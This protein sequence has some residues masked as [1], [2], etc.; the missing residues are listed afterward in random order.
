MPVKTGS[1]K[2]RQGV[3]N[4]TI[5][6]GGGINS[7]APEAQVRPE[8][9][10]EGENFDLELDSGK[11]ARRPP[12]DLLG[13]ATNAEEIR[14]FAQ[15]LK[16]DGTTSAL[17]QAGTKVYEWDGATGFTDTTVSVNA[18][19]K[20]RG[21]L[22][23]NF[24]LDD[25]VLI[26][27]L[28]LLE[29]VYE[30]DGATLQKVTFPDKTNFKAKYCFVEDERAFFGNISESAT[31]V[32]HMVVGSAVSDYTDITVSNRAGSTGISGDA[33][34]FYVLTP[35]LRPVN[36]MLSAFG[37]TI[38]SSAEGRIW[39]FT[40]NDATDYRL[41]SLYF[42]SAS[43]GDE[44][45]VNVGNDVFYGRQGL[46]ESLRSTDTFGNVEADDLT[47]WIKNQIADRT[48]WQAEFNSRTQRVFFFPSGQDKIWV[49]HKPLLDARTGLSPWS[50]WT[51]QGDFT[52]QQPT[53]VMRMFDPSTGLENIFFGDASGNIYRLEGSGSSGD[54]GDSNIRAF[55][56]SHLIEHGQ[57]G[58]LFDFLGTLRYRQVDPATVGVTVMWGG[59]VGYDVTVNVSLGAVSGA[60]FY[61]GDAYFGGEVYFG[62]P[63]R[64]RLKRQ[65]VSV[66]GS[67][68][69]I[70]IELEVDGTGTFDIDQ[71][72]I[73]TE[74]FP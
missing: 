42:N 60:S 28:A 44:A 3:S 32:P 63:F 19:A 7:V 69:D 17:V 15:L 20:L 2:Q 64:Q 53:A 48:S 18:G 11:F 24:T 23:H 62:A 34:A 25:K 22:E 55:R 35:D 47:R 36:A 41:D 51:T 30:W 73:Q 58:E 39:F 71:L 65:P 40:G 1:Q 29:D 31:A 21:R 27:D 4:P 52:L 59:N 37:K 70:Q 45:V 54:G 56:K 61:G 13:T 57:N 9:C 49:C 43:V 74:A 5:R 46:I 72:E 14:G 33:D 50:L 6:F 68:N 8:E 16:A 67:G 38:I 10:T 26:T 12:I 66:A